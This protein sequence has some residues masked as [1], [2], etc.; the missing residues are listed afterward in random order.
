MEDSEIYIWAILS[1]RLW[2]HQ[3]VQI[4]TEWCLIWTVLT[5]FNDVIIHLWL[6]RRSPLSLST[7]GPTN[8]NAG[9]R[10]GSSQKM[11]LKNTVAH[12]RFHTN[13]KVQFSLYVK[14]WLIFSPIHAVILLMAPGSY[15]L[16]VITTLNDKQ[17]HLELGSDETR[18]RCEVV[19]CLN[20]RTDTLP[21]RY[22]PVC[23]CIGVIFSSILLAI[24]QKL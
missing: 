12:A 10:L 23:R 13:N 5:L 9:E 19:S 20:V 8:W 15:R 16:R 22:T 2:S 7:V 3:I 17:F 11:N 18:N 24:S 6:F 21:D 14:K 4:F 1:S